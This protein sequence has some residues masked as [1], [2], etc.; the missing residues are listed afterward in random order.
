MLAHFPPCFLNA[1]YMLSLCYCKTSKISCCSLVCERLL[2][3]RCTG[4]F[5]WRQRVS[6]GRCS[7]PSAACAVLPVEEPSSSGRESIS[8][9]CGDSS[10]L[11]H[12]LRLAAVVFRN[13]PQQC[14]RQGD[15]A[16]SAFVKDLESKLFCFSYPAIRALNRK[17][18]LG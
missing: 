1:F 12:G 17:E 2:V 5:E 13:I 14:E 6:L 4:Q 8:L 16:L 18:P 15:Q 10:M 3:F 9:S 7:A 11:Q